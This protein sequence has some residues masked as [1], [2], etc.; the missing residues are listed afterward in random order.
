MTKCQTLESQYGGDPLTVDALVPTAVMRVMLSRTHV[1]TSDLDVAR[2][3]WRR[4]KIS[5]EDPRWTRELRRQTLAAAL[6][7]HTEGR[8]EYVAVMSGNL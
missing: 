1:A 4:M 5:A 7:L 3:I 6:W 8:R 2:D